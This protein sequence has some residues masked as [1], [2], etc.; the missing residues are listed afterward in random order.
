[1]VTEPETPQVDRPGVG[2][3]GEI[4]EPH[5]DA[6][7]GVAADDQLGEGALEEVDDL[8]SAP[9]QATGPGDHGPASR[10]EPVEPVGEHDH[11]VGHPEHGAEQPD[12]R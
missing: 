2:L 3:V 4:E 5:I 10:G 12:L 1:M 11:A 7:V 6:T 9:G 8:G